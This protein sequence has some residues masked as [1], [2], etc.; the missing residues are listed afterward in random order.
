MATAGRYTGNLDWSTSHFR[1]DI[2]DDYAAID[3]I[4]ANYYTAINCM[5]SWC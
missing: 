4:R 5:Y 3:D 1:I 2:D